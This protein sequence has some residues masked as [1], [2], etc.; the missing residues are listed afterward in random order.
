MVQGNTT[1]CKSVQCDGVHGS[2]V[3]SGTVPGVIGSQPIPN[4]QPTAAPNPNNPG[5]PT[6]APQ[7][8]PQKI[9]TLCVY[10]QLVVSKDG[11]YL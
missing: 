9:G 11:G 4:L 3:G 7:L 1:C 6:P 10:T 5:G 2:F 8:I